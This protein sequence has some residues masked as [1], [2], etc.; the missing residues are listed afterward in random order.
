MVR[1]LIVALCVVSL[2]VI[3]ALLPHS[4][5]VGQD[6]GDGAMPQP[7]QGKFL[8]IVK[9]CSPTSSVELEKV[10]LKKL[11]G[12]NFM[13]GT[14]IDVPGNWQKGLEVWVALDEVAMVT[15]FPT[16]EEFKRGI[17]QPGADKER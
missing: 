8:S 9:R 16:L 17:V 15:S 4:P 1:L 2:A 14:G 12:R 13:V 6:R 10:Q 11:E 3:V 5:V 7:F